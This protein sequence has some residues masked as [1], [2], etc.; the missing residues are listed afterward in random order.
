MIAEVAKQ[1]TLD[2]MLDRDPKA[3]SEQGLKDLIETERSRR[4]FFTGKSRRAANEIKE[5]EDGSEEDSNG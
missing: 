2:T 4:P 5:T 3:L 1:P